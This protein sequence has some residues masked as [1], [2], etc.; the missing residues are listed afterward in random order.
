M[1]KTKILKHPKP[2]TPF[3]PKMDHLESMNSIIYLGSDPTESE[4]FKSGNRENTG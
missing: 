1:G 3:P 2:V 4:I